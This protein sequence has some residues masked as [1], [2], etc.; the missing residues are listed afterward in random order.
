MEPYFDHEKLQVYQEAI[1]FVAWWGEVSKRCAGIPSV[2]DQMDRASTSIPLNIAEGNGKY[3]PRDRSRYLQ[4]AYGSALECASCLDVIVARRCMTGQ[5]A[6]IGKRKL[7]G[8]VAM[9]V[10]LINQVSSRVAEE[11]AEYDPL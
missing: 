1:G 7:R 3:S 9:L 10:G 8:I 4:I 11:P 6:D 5:E 2:K